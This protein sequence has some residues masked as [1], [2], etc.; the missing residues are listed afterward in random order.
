MDFRVLYT[1][2]DLLVEGNA[3]QLLANVKLLKNSEAKLVA[4]WAQT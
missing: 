3:W 2:S 1:L 4:M